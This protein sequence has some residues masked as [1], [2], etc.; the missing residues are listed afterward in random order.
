MKHPDDTA[1]YCFRALESLK[2]YCRARFKIDS[3]SDQWKKLSEITGAGKDDIKFIREKAFPVRH[4][5]VVGIT[6]DDRVKMF[7]T[8]WD[9]V[10]AFLCNA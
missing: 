4:G 7:L 3:E 9:I 10:D 1:F 8:T 6:S 2:Y 5:D